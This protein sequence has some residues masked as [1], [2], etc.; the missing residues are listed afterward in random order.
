VMKEEVLETGRFP[1][2][3]FESTRISVA[4]GAG[5]S[6]TAEVTGRLSLHGVTRDVTFGAQAVLMG[7]TLRAFGTFSLRQTDF[8]IKLVSVAAG[9]LK[10]KDEVSGSFDIV[11]RKRG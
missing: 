6:P 7:D 5:G 8:G 4:A 9:G 3:T 2:I 11:A 1:D 10:V